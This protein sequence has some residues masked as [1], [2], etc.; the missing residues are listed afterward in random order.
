MSCPAGYD[1]DAG[2]C[3]PACGAGSRG[4]GPVCWAYCA[5]ELPVECGAGCARTSEVCAEATA[6]KVLKSAETVVSLALQ[7]WGGALESGIAAANEFNLPLCG[8]PPS[9]S[10]SELRIPATLLH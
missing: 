2:L 8:G 10:P 7:N 5:G 3:Y 1:T 4:V 9:F 6:S